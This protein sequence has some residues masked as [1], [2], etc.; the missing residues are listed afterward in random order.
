MSQ[1]DYH[2]EEK[3]DPYWDQLVQDLT[4]FR[5]APNDRYHLDARDPSTY[6]LDPVSVF[7]HDLMEDYPFLGEI[8]G[9]VKYQALEAFPVN[10]QCTTDFLF[11]RNPFRF[12]ECGS[13]DPTAVNPGV[14]YLISYWLAA[15]HKF[16]PKDM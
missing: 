12:E 1:G 10:L 15:Y 14:D 9:N 5:D 16:I 7:L 6:T 2:P 4:D 3:D 11:Q 8:M 13:D